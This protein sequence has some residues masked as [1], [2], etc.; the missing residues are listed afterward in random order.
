MDPKHSS[1]TSI[2]VRPRRFIFIIIFLELVWSEVSVHS[3][4]C[5]S[6]H[7]KTSQIPDVAESDSTLSV[8]SAKHM[9]GP[10]KIGI[11]FA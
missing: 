3:K 4:R 8:I 11:L 7:T 9:A 10:R 5:K 6:K 2:S 1:E